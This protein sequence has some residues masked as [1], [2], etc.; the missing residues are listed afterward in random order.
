MR[1]VELSLGFSTADGYE[2]CLAFDG[3]N[4]TLDFI[5]WRETHQTT[6]FREVLAFRWGREL[7]QGVP[8]DDNSYEVLES[9]WLTREVELAGV[10]QDAILYAHYKLCFCGCGNLDVLCLRL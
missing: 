7:P 2:V 5:D 4:L 9:D 8:R 6:L 10:T 3:K 1:Y